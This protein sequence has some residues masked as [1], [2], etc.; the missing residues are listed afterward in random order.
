MRK[1]ID[2]MTEKEKSGGRYT[3][4]KRKSVVDMKNK[5]YW[6]IKEKREK[7]VA[8]MK[9]KKVTTTTTEIGGRHER[10]K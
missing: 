10:E 9:G 6:F 4:K 5:D 1:S 2:D 3:R 8:N 7:S